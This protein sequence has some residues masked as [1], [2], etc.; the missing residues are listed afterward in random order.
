LKKAWALFYLNKF[1]DAIHTY[2]SAF[3]ISPELKNDNKIDH[4][5]LFRKISEKRS[6]LQKE[7]EKEKEKEIENVNIEISLSNL[8]ESINIDPSNAILYLNRCSIYYQVGKFQ[9][10]IDDATNSI[11]LNPQLG[12]SYVL[13]AWSF[14]HLNQFDDALR[15]YRQGFQMD[16]HLKESNESDYQLLLKQIV[17]S[18][19]NLS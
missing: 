14:F 6:Q 5:D 1:D 2:K 4:E 13:Q 12:K 16:P 11:Q 3:D 17:Q 7:K 10:A 18:Q 8:T 19:E 15:S 9:F